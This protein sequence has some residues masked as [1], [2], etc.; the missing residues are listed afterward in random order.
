[1]SNYASV[2]RAG[3]SLVL[4]SPNDRVLRTLTL[5]HLVPT[6]FEVIEV[7]ETGLRIHSKSA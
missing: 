5:T 2:K 3:G 4:L 7:I 6:V 1:M